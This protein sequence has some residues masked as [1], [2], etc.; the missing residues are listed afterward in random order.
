MPG[1][2][3]IQMKCFK[4]A[5]ATVSAVASGIAIAKQYLV[6]L[7]SLL[8]HYLRHPLLHYLELVVA[9]ELHRILVALIQEST[10]SFDEL[11]Q[12]SVP[13]HARHKF[14]LPDDEVASTTQSFTIMRK[15]DLVNTP[16]YQGRTPLYLAARSRDVVN[17]RLL[18]EHGADA[19]ILSADG[20]SVLLAVLEKQPMMSEDN[21]VLN[22]MLMLN[23]AG[24]SLNEQNKNENNILILSFKRAQ[25]KTAHWILAPAAMSPPSGKSANT[26]R[27]MQTK[28]DAGAPLDTV[29]ARGRNVSHLA[30]ELKLDETLKK[31][32]ARRDDSLDLEAQDYEGRTALH[33]AAQ[34]RN[35]KIVD[36][37]LEARASVTSRTHERKTVMHSLL[38]E[39]FES[40][41]QKEEVNEIFDALAAA[42]APL[43][44]L[45]RRN[46]SLLHLAAKHKHGKILELLLKKCQHEEQTKSSE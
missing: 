21:V 11:Q 28:L 43:T 39:S 26:M 17:V 46:Q 13:T 40:S 38:D 3:N 5:S 34:M 16:D 35:K 37:L 14:K 25:S 20:S 41:D 12:K 8:R 9:I 23:D 31:L 24:A 32:L 30:A 36:L 7:H 2:P 19:K 44:A 33:V 42:G 29:D 45:D 4:N 27:L 18:L 1:F 15:Q 6:K 22:L 10:R